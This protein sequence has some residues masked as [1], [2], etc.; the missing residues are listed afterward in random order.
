MAL[1]SMWSSPLYMSNDLRDL[2][3]EHK[4]ILQNKYVIA[5]NKDPLGIMAQRVYSV[6][7]K[8]KNL[9][10]N[11]LK[12]F[13]L[14][15]IFIFFFNYKEFSGHRNLGQTDHTSNQWSLFIRNRISE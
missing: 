10:K 5:V 2:R 7:N 11:K 9:S 6:F 14:S 3:S 13:S 8:K 4:E 12:F 1:W 15:N